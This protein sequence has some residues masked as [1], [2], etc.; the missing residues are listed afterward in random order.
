[1]LVT[2]VFLLYGSSSCITD[3]SDLALLL[4]IIPV[5]SMMAFVATKI[6]DY[7]DDKL[8][9]TRHYTIERSCKMKQTGCESPAISSPIFKADLQI[10]YEACITVSLF[11]MFAV[12]KKIVFVCYSTACP[13]ETTVKMKP[14]LFIL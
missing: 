11:N 4:V 6:P 9:V 3:E 2:A 14:S 1:M 13:F 8:F 12:C 5:Q 7:V 10:L